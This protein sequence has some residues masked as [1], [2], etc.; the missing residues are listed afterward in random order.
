MRVARAENDK[1]YL[2]FNLFMTLSIYLF[3][4]FS[5]FTYLSNTL[6]RLHTG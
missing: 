1:I 4:D 6:G 2:L 5:V 3:H